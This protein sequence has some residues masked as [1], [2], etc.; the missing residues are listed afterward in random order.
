MG[1]RVAKVGRFIRWWME[2]AGGQ[3]TSMLS[4]KESHLPYRHMGI[5]IHKAG[6][7]MHGNASRHAYGHA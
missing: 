3:V 7:D 4:V 1:E 2:R 5:D 6:I